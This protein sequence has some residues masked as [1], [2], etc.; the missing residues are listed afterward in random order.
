MLLL[1][2]AIASLG[3]AVY[4]L[5]EVATLPAR[6]R[7]GSIRRAANYGHS[8]RLVNPF[9]QTAG[10]R[11]RAMGPAVTS[12]ARVVLRVSPKSTVESINLKL[13]GAGLG[14]SFS[15]TAFL[16]TKGILAM[17]G[18]LLGLM[19]GSGSG[20]KGVL[21]AFGLGV[22]GLM[23]P[24]TVLTFKGR[25]RRDRI[26]A[27]LPD[28]LDLLAVSVEA[29]LGFDG[30][31]TKLTEHMDGPLAEEF[32]LSLGEMRIG[33]SRSEA[34]KK[35]SERVGSPAMAA[36][37]RAVIQADQLGISLGRILRLQAAEARN[38]RQAAAEERAM[39]API[40]MLFPTVLFIFP[41]MFIVIL[42]PAFMNLSKLF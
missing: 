32:A 41:A 26:Q 5:G 37:T 25:S 23:L 33:E 40:K 8:R 4:L 9:A 38:R 35:M 29:G 13:L 36:F 20:S 21:I 3:L 12:L 11:E 10:F 42:G 34:L 22:M 14:R 6:Q 2:L 28:A 7:Q 15:P 31:I 19:A 27:E 16:A 24:D 18:L 30:A 17:M 1:V 39:K